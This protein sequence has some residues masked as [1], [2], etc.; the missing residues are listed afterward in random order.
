MVVFL[1]CGAQTATIGYCRSNSAQCLKVLTIDR[2]V[3]VDAE[4]EARAGRRGLWAD[5]DP[6][7]PWDFRHNK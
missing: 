2:Q 1:S 6:V 4:N 3:Y 5:A 7:P